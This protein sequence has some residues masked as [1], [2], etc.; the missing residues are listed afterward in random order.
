MSR[1]IG[2]IIVIE[3]QRKRIIGHFVL[4]V[5]IM[6]TLQRSVIKFMAIPL[7]LDKNKSL[8]IL[9]IMVLNLSIIALNILV[10]KELK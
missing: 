9:S 2:L 7:V 6:V 4:I 8:A 1:I 10:L 5:T 3:V